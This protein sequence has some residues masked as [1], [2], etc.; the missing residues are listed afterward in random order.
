MKSDQSSDEGG[1]H[2]SGLGVALGALKDGTGKREFRSN[3]YQ[4]ADPIEEVD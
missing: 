2:I 1:S 4:V 3:S